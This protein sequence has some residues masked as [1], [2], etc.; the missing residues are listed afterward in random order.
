MAKLLKNAN[1]LTAQ[2]FIN[3]DVLISQGKL[4]LDFSNHPKDDFINNSIDCS[5]FY[6][7]P[8]FATTTATSSP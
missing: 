6:I 7:T 5:N 1:V 4:F 2:G 3:S 8:G